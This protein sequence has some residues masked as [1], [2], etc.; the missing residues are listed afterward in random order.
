L[1]EGQSLQKKGGIEARYF[2]AH[3]LN[4][5]ACIQK[6]EDQLRR[7]KLRSELWLTVGFSDIYCDL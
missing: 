3:L 2:I 7:T 4:A 5:A 6:P 1:E